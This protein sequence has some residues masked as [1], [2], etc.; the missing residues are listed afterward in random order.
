MAKDD[1]IL[2]EAIESVLL[3]NENPMRIS[4]LVSIL[5]DEY[6]E[7]RGEDLINKVTEVDID[8]CV[9]QKN[10]LFDN[11]FGVISL[12]DQKHK[13]I[14]EIEN[15]LMEYVNKSSANSILDFI[16]CYLLF[17]RYAAVQ[18]YFALKKLSTGQLI[19]RT[20]N[21]PDQL[22]CKVITNLVDQFSSLYGDNS[23]KE[24]F[25]FKNEEIINQRLAMLA[26][27][28]RCY[29]WRVNKLS[30]ENFDELVLNL[31]KRTNFYH[32]TKFLTPKKVSQFT[33][34]LVDKKNTGKITEL[35]SQF[36]E[37][38]SLASKGI[39]SSAEIEI[40][41]DDIF[42]TVLGCLRVLV[43]GYSNV[44]MN[45]SVFTSHQNE[46]FDIV[47]AFPPFGNLQKSFLAE[48]FET[49][50]I[51]IS[52][53]DELYSRI[54]IS[55]L[56][57]DGKAY[58]ILREDFLSSNRKSYVKFREKLTEKGWLDTI[59]KLPR[60]WMYP[61]TAAN[62]YLVILNLQG[63]D[64]TYFFDLAEFQRQDQTA[65]DK[66][67]SSASDLIREKVTVPKVARNVNQSSI[68]EL[69]CDLRV[70]KYVNPIYFPEEYKRS[71]SEQ[72]LKI[73][74]LVTVIRSKREKVTNEHP[75]VNMTQ[76]SD[77]ASNY[78][79]DLKG[80]PK[81]KNY[82]KDQPLLRE[83][84]LLV[85]TVGGNLKPTLFQYNSNPIFLGSNVYSLR[86]DSDRIDPEYL[87]FELNTEFVKKQVS[88]Y[89]KGVT[90]PHINKS[91]LMNIVVRVPEKR[92]QARLFNEWITG[93]ARNQLESLNIE[94][95][96]LFSEEF[97]LIHDMHH[98]LKNELTILKGAFRDIKSYLY[99]K[100]KSKKVVDLAE[101]I[102]EIKKGADPSLYDS[103]D[104]KLVAMEKSLF[105]MSSFVKDYKSIL[106]FDPKKQNAEWIY[107]KDFLE[108]LCSEY[109]D[110]EYSVIEE[111]TD[112]TSS[113]KVESFQLKID[114]GLFRMI[115]TNIIENA[116]N[117]GFE[118]L[119]SNK[120]IEFII[121]DTYD[122]PDFR[123]IKDSSGKIID[124][125]DIADNWIEL[126][127]RN[128]G[129]IGGE[130]IDFQKVFERGYGKGSEK[131]R[132][133][134]LTHVQKAMKSIK[135]KV[136]IIKPDDPIFTFEIKLKFPVSIGKSPNYVTIDTFTI[137]D[138]ND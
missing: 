45:S 6:L 86:I 71:E 114:K 123:D 125:I 84:A 101:S 18:D 106:K 58:L 13:S 81:K 118:G 95:E 137:E 29:D 9:R 131:N 44:R 46:G 128:T 21:E 1:K 64:S 94:K 48:K 67:L 70:H 82:S 10:G 92:E 102:R 34:L 110:F 40:S 36:A 24:K 55:R 43:K 115:I 26:K 3:R 15:E 117:H 28:V 130:E 35:Y 20:Y 14:D 33:Q 85:G 41:T 65:E 57:S 138:E 108:N 113:T 8:Q 93:I 22:D 37:F 80:L 56:R 73:E 72:L 88:R 124:Q 104:Q 127:V 69:D 98:T 122:E 126:V 53:F 89:T 132:G 49:K 68:L 2:V 96:K 119:E 134:G 90:I 47:F 116:K 27:I 87:I 38:I 52:S 51:E 50:E 77:Q 83:D 97:D 17:L 16:I 129:R 54:A 109:P 111:I 5:N 79:L 4:E 107:L 7:K 62:F 100:S 136:E 76:L 19:F 11:Y 78:L 63:V 61:Q 75:F 31:R 133:I 103:V 66:I 112:K 121:R 135:G 25:T 91:D 42:N 99:K 39:N 32:S 120:F 60:E 59:V 30:S 105:Q 23:S 12:K 74:D